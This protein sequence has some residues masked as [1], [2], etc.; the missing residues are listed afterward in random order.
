MAVDCTSGEIL[1][2]FTP[3]QSHYYPGPELFNLI[4]ILT[5][6]DI[7]QAIRSSQDANIA[8]VKAAK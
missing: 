3:T 2:L 1:M 6:L 8:D 7:S 5:A 4:K